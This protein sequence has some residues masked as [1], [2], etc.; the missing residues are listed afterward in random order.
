M[1]S[2]LIASL[3]AAAVVFVQVPLAQ[4]AP[5]NG[6]SLAGLESYAPQA[7]AAGGLRNAAYFVNW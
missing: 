2:G 4:A 5:Q 1:F 7:A 3:A 6:N